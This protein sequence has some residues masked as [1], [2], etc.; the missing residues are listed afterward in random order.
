MRPEKCWFQRRDLAV[1]KLEDRRL[2]AG[3]PAFSSRPGASSALYLDFDGHALPNW[4]NYQNARVNAYQRTDL[5]DDIWRI[6]AEDFAPF[7][8]NV[9]TVLPTNKPFQRVAIGN[10]VNNWVPENFTGIGAD[11]EG[12]WVFADAFANG[13]LLQELGNTTSHEAGHAYGLSHHTAGQTEYF[14]GGNAWTPIMGNNYSADRHLWYA[15]ETR[16]GQSVQNDVAVLTNRLGLAADDHAP[17]LNA[18]KNLNVAGN[19]LTG[20]GTI[21]VGTNTSVDLDLFK[22]NTSG[23][24]VTFTLFVGSK[25]LPYAS[26]AN[27]WHRNKAVSNANLNAYLAIYNPTGQQ[28]AAADPNDSQGASLNVKLPAGK[29][30]LGVQPKAPEV[31][32]GRQMVG[33]LGQYAI[34]G[35]A[36]VSTALTAP[37][38]VRAVRVNRTTANLSWTDAANNTGYRVFRQDPAT[39]KWLLL[40]T[41]GAN[42]TTYQYKNANAFWKENFQVRSFNSSTAKISANFSVELTIG[43]FR[44]AVVSRTTV[45]FNWR[46][47]T[48]ETGY[49]LYRWNPTQQ[50]AV[51]IA[52]LAANVTAFRYTNQN[53]GVREQFLLQAFNSGG[54]TNTDW[55]VVRLA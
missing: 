29:Y 23:G 16:N 55:E 19:T 40:A 53:L 45:Q 11:G 38:N 42:A 39:Q 25:F 48:G 8:V 32:D 5:I 4:L 51:L 6:V 7:N 22:F 14:N 17:T 1:E 12:A 31:L 44:A 9:T 34:R 47:F 33:N 30:Y 52:T 26:N 2:M 46:D 49:R 15:G 21:N 37:T 54:V 10:E 13:S 27:N 50:R 24:T 18:A 36:P 35:T 3:V 20:S 28:I 41:L 43:G